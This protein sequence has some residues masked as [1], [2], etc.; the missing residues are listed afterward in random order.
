[1]NRQFY[2]QHGEDYLL[3][4]VLGV[5]RSH[6]YFVDV[7]AFDGIHLSNSY[8]FERAGWSGI[9]VEAHP[10]FFPH[11]Q[12]NRPGSRCVHA[13][14]VENTAAGTAAFLTEPLGLLS[15]IKADKTSGMERRYANRGMTFPGFTRI[16]VPSMTLTGI[17]REANAPRH[18]DFL[19]LD[20]E[21]TEP[22]V[23]A[24]LD[25]AEF[26]FRIIVTEANTAEGL[27]E[28]RG[29]LEARGYV[30]ARSLGVNHVFAS[31]KEDARNAASTRI[32]CRIEDVLH[33]LGEQATHPAARGRII[34]ES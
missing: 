12:A 27:A 23:L 2:S 13:A 26:A 22:Q 16:E 7:G 4:Q 8:S 32:D 33:P 19:S 29:L 5:E 20:V 25:Q 24:A 17:L 21:G 14:C 11:L 3:W 1:M 10:G 31:N 6:G 34:R 30:F 15:G 28:T 18:M 9:C